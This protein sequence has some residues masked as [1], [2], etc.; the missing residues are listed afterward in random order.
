METLNREQ[1]LKKAGINSVNTDEFIDYFNEMF[2]DGMMI[3]GALDETGVPTFEYD[4]EKWKVLFRVLGHMY[5]PDDPEW[6]PE[7]HPSFRKHLW[8]DTAEVVRNDK[9]GKRQ[10]PTEAS[11]KPK[12]VA[13]HALTGKPKPI[14][15]ETCDDRSGQAS[16]SEEEVIS[17]GSEVGDDEYPTQLLARDHLNERATTTKKRGRKSS[18][19]ATGRNAE[20]MI[21]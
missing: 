13:R 7:V 20:T 15:E 19:A 1:R 21:L 11:P 3:E 4:E 16:G 18:E 2:R 17:K 5:F 12:P 6:I 9:S 10:V 8:P 14:P